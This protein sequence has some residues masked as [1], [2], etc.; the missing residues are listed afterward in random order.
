MTTFESAAAS[1]RPR[2]PLSVRLAPVATFLRAN[3]LPLTF[4]LTLVLGLAF[5]AAAAFTVSVGLGLL[6]TGAALV[7]GGHWV[8]YLR[9]VRAT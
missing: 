5:V 9:T 3:E 6:V 4:V 8:T 2:V 7:L 1:V